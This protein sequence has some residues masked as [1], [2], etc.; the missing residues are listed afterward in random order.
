M[1]KFHH[2]EMYFTPSSRPQPQFSESQNT[3]PC[4][5][6]QPQFSESQHTPPRKSYQDKVI[7]IT[8]ARKTLLNLFQNPMFGQPHSSQTGKSKEDLGKI[9]PYVKNKLNGTFHS[10]KQTSPKVRE[11]FK[12]TI[13]KHKSE[14]KAHIFVL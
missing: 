8:G 14:P 10:M 5:Y 4:N 6:P 2:S 1:E 9:S 3:P 13:K 11:G 12:K 7:K